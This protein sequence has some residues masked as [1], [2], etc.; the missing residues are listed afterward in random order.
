MNI[1]IISISAIIIIIVI[2]IIVV[3]MNSSDDN[4]VN[5]S[6]NSLY[7]PEI[8]SSDT[9]LA[10]PKTKT[11]ITAYQECPTG[12]YGEISR[13]C[14]NGTWG[15]E[16]RTKCKE[17][18]D[19]P[20]D[21][22]W[23]KTAGKTFAS[24]GCPT[25]YVGS[26]RR[27]CYEDGTWGDEEI[28]CIQLAN[29]NNSETC[30]IIPV[31]ISSNQVL[32]TLKIPLF[33]DID[34]NGELKTVDF[35]FSANIDSIAKDYDDIKDTIPAKLKSQTGEDRTYTYPDKLQV[36]KNDE[37]LIVV[38]KHMT[39]IITYSYDYPY[40][41]INNSLVTIQSKTFQTIEPRKN[42]LYK[43]WAY[44]P[45]YDT[46]D[47]CKNSVVSMRNIKIGYLYT[48]NYI[49]LCLIISAMCTSD[50]DVTIS[51][52]GDCTVTFESYKGKTL[53]LM[54]STDKLCSGVY[55]FADIKNNFTNFCKT[56]NLANGKGWKYTIDL[57]KPYNPT[58]TVYSLSESKDITI[59][60][61][62]SN[63]YDSNYDGSSEIADWIPQILCNHIDL[64]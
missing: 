11:G 18:Q 36:F 2:I 15:N 12:F 62:G 16:D 49:N 41:Y 37:Y 58:P 38:S 45:K 39:K 34:D 5:S 48:N 52:L 1:L 20:A 3:V 17:I 47:D 29:I 27:F 60:D 35:T 22:D 61:T 55:T 4:T 40:N 8:N 9:S 51:S 56:Y 19:C 57:N 46:E 64:Q 44:I 50:N 33:G 14:N 13:T 30:G 31:D 43:M 32:I 7:C 10:W 23:P 21:G 24:I 28:K 59:F 25:D 63:M 26:H 54:L 53:F 42:L 6:S